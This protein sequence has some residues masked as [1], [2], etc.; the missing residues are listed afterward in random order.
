MWKVRILKLIGMTFKKIP[1]ETLLAITLT[2]ILKKVST[3]VDIEKVLTT[4]KHCTEALGIMSD[5]ISNSEVSDKE[6]NMTT[7][8][9]NGLRIELLDAWSKQK[10]A[11]EIESKIA[12]I[13]K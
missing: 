6:V 2:W 11:K 7:S 5:I 10:P 1:V 12:S 3:K 4:I 8:T 9:V 13:I